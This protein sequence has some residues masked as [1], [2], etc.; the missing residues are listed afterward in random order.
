MGKAIPQSNAIE[1][2]SADEDLTLEEREFA[3]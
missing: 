2:Y 3:G 1:E